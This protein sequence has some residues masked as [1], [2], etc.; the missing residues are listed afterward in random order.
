M[1]PRARVAI[2]RCLAAL[3]L[4]AALWAVPAAATAQALIPEQGL[5]FGTVQPG[6]SSYVSP[7][8]PDRG[9]VSVVAWGRIGI[10]I[11]PPTALV[12]PEGHQL[13]FDMAVGDAMV[14]WWGGNSQVL[15]PGA[16]TT[17]NGRL[18]GAIHIGGTVSPPA[19]Q[20]AGTYTGAIVVQIVAPGT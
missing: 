6:V 13:P 19:D 4:A 16:T 2:P 18:F 8:D 5:S 15:V 17:A 14:R 11:L 3:A 7:D 10:R 1:S 9:V 12:S 20:G